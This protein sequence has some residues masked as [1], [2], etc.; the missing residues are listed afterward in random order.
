MLFRFWVTRVQSE[1]EEEEEEEDEQNSII[2][3]YIYDA[4][5]HTNPYILSTTVLSDTDHDV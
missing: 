4:K 3:P 2:A 5:Y 1:E